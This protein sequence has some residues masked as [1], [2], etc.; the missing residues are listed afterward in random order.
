MSCERGN[1]CARAS[2][3]AVVARLSFLKFDELELDEL[4]LDEDAFLK[5]LKE[6]LAGFVA[7]ALFEAAAEA[8]DDDA[9]AGMG[10]VFGDCDRLLLIRSARSL[11]HTQTSPFLP[12]F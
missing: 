1:V 9:R 12:D 10:M 6:N 7:A 2:C 11:E 5:V 3:T 8:L 4:D